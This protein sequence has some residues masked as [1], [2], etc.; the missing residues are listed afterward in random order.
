MDEVIQP[1]T[2]VIFHIKTLG[3]ILIDTAADDDCKP[4][5]IYVRFGD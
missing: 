2:R 5:C 3:S 1:R 4:N